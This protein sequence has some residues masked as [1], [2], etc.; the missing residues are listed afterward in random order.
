MTGT[1]SR[2]IFSPRNSP[3][4]PLQIK[5]RRISR[6]GPPVAVSD[7]QGDARSSGCPFGRARP[8]LAIYTFLR[9]PKK[10]AEL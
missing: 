8:G 2:K 9:F 1:V 7:V 3:G 4:I 6:R 5:E 10:R